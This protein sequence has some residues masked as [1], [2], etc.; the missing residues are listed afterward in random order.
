[1]SDGVELGSGGRETAFAEEGKVKGDGNG[2]TELVGKAMEG[3]G[4]A[5]RGKA[6]GT[7]KRRVGMDGLVDL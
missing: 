2:V 4:L 7:G 5:G 6:N 3:L 1:M